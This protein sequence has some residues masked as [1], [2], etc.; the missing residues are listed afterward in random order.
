[1]VPT[2]RFWRKRNRRKPNYDSA[3]LSPPSVES[4]DLERKWIARVQAGVL[5]VRDP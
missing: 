4:L 5:I 1:M 3:E 2:V